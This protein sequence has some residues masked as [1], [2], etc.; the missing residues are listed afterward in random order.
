MFCAVLTLEFRERLNIPSSQ[1]LNPLSKKSLARKR[2]DVIDIECDEDTILE[3]HLLE[4][5][6]ITNFK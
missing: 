1:R 5:L 3:R 6:F 4:E 2:K